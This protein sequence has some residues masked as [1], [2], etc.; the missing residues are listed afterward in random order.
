MSQR[1][2]RAHGFGKRA[3]NMAVEY[4]AAVLCFGAN[5]DQGVEFLRRAGRDCAQRAGDSA[6]AEQG[7]LR[8]SRHFYT[9]H[10]EERRFHALAAATVHIVDIDRDR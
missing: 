2:A 9:I 8:P 10:I 7:A 3:R 4:E 6:F 5:P 1:Q